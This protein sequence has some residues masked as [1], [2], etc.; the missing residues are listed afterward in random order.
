MARSSRSTLLGWPLL[1]MTLGLACVALVVLEVGRSV[2]GNREVATRAR[3]GYVRFALWS[4]REH[5]AETMRNAAREALGAVNHGEALHVSPRIP[6][7]AELGHFLPYSA[8]CECHRPR[9]GPLP[10]AFYGF[11]IGADTVGV[12]PNFAPAPDAGWLADPVPGMSLPEAGRF[13][14]APAEG[15]WLSGLLTAEARD[16]F[17]TWGYRYAIAD[18]EGRPRFFVA[19]LMP[20]ARGDTILYAAEYRAEAID[21]LLGAVLDD[22]ALLPL[23][24]D[25]RTPPVGFNRQALALEVSGPGGQRLFSWAPPTAWPTPPS[26]MPPSYG[27]LTIQAAILPQMLDKLVIGGM[28]ADNTPILL[29]LLALAAGLT[30][31][32]GVQ[33]RR[34]LR[35]ARARA[36]FVASVSH[37]LRTPLTQIR[38]LLD[39]VR[40]PAREGR[41][42]GADEL[43][44][45]DREVLRLQQLVDRVL[46]F[47][48]TEEGAVPMPRAVVALGPEV[49][50]IVDE[51]RP[52]AA[53][54]GLVIDTQVAAEPR[55]ALEPDGLRQVLLNLLDNAVKYAA[56]GGTVTVTV[57]AAEGLARL[58]VEDRGSGIPAAERERIFEGY[59]RGSAATARAVGGSGI[60][61]TVVRAI[62]DRHDGSVRVETAEGGGAR[63]IVSL[64]EAP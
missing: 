25:A 4:Y 16:G 49:V 43:G 41:P 11:T 60:G 55:V 61:L 3:V 26:R 45:V 13:R 17:S 42:V 37:E 2:R 54:R 39:T 24:L 7:A 53:A 63:F 8:H 33:L 18:W 32:A 29:G 10:L 58:V 57:A 64:P 31:V 40:M 62:A 44:M 1:V 23:A 59:V 15:H 48:R 36:D 27:G 30:V 19:T 5:L 14:L 6:P 56:D 51:F 35:F 50:A 47:R 34:E 28:P 9:F 12:G 38:L 20:T 52:L 22:P 46:H 21:S